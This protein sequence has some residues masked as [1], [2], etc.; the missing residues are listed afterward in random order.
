MKKVALTFTVLVGVNYLQAQDADNP[1]RID[2]GVNAVDF[3]PTNYVINNSKGGRVTG[4]WLD[5]YVNAN[6][7]YNILPSFS[8]FCNR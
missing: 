2:V 7:H 8:R 5:E 3:Y 6:D 4:K 1:W